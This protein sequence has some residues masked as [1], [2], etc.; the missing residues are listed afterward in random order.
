MSVE[1][2]KKEITKFLCDWFIVIVIT[3]EKDQLNK[4]RAWIDPSPKVKKQKTKPATEIPKAEPTVSPLV[5][6]Y[7]KVKES[8]PP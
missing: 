1:E 8:E 6:N 4:I 3:L 7:I 2:V 5:F